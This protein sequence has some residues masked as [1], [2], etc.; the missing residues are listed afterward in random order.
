MQFENIYYKGRYF[1]MAKSSNIDIVN[2]KIFK[3]LLYYTLPIMFTGILQL[4]YNAADIIV[5]GRYAGS[6]SLAAVGSTGALINLFT[7]LFIGLA[8]G[9][10]VCVAHFIGA[11][12]SDAVHK[13]VHTSVGVSVIA[14][15]FLLIVGV[16]LSKPILSLMNTPSDILDE[17][18]LYMKIIFAG[19]PAMLLYNYCAA[20]VRANG[21]TK[22]PLIYLSI[23]G[24]LNVV[25][26]LL[27]VIVF[28]RGADGVGLATIISQYLSAFLIVRHLMKIN[29]DIKLTLSEIRIDKY[30]LLRIMKIGIPSGIQGILFSISNVLIQSSVNG[31]GSIAVAGNSA[32]GNVEGFAYVAMNSTHQAVLTFT[33]QNVGAK[34]YDR[35][36]R[37]VAV[38]SVQVTMIGISICIILLAFAT[39][40]LSLYAPGD[41]EVISTGINRMLVILPAYCLCGLMEVFVGSLRGMGAALPSMLISVF[42]VCGMRIVWI[43]TIFRHFGTLSSLYLS[44]P[45]T[46]L[47]TGLVQLIY[48]MILIQKT[49]ASNK[50]NSI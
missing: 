42:G 22:T 44:Y 4:L 31:F 27:F 6:N 37:I 11:K 30:M 41:E 38:G 39:P 10:N 7:N 32:A 13:S 29:S 46:W 33:G 28:K 3:N 8:T 2:G 25:L 45:A 12:E 50:N 26:N 34:R 24:I 18:A 14:G 21:D 48:C 5:V 20:I 1:K 47:V 49:I 23:T 36:K 15:F 19:M 16:I 40:L 35:L 9:T 43:Y 17:A